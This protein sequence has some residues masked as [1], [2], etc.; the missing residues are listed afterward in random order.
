MNFSIG[1]DVWHAGIA[2]HFCH[3]SK[4]PDIEK[5]LLA[6]KNPG[7]VE[8]VL[9]QFCPIPKSEFSLSKHLEQ[10]KSFSASS[11]EGIIKN[12]EEDNSKWAKQTIEVPF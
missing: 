7:E 3:S 6:L 10:I 1:E 11:V 8:R 2:T 5:A 12:L 4:L 9:N